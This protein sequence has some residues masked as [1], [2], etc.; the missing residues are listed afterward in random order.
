VL[1]G[2]GLPLDE[3][4][5]LEVEDEAIRTEEECIEDALL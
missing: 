1:S 5:A 3:G 2:V 4:M